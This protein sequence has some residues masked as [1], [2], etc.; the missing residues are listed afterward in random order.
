MDLARLSRWNLHVDMTSEN[1]H[2]FGKVFESFACM[3]YQS[4]RVAWGI[5]PTPCCLL[6]KSSSNS[7]N[8]NLFDLALAVLWLVASGRQAQCS[9]CITVNIIAYSPNVCS[10]VVESFVTFQVSG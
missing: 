7:R 4:S 9:F 10:L 2:E 8:W 6:L 5:S 1:P 3:F